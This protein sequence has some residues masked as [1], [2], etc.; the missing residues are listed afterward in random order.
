MAERSFWENHAGGRP[1]RHG[2]TAWERLMWIRCHCGSTDCTGE[3]VLRASSDG[4][5]EG[6]CPE[7]GV[8]WRLVG[9]R[10]RGEGSPVDGSLVTA[11][12]CECGHP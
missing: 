3:V 9:G 7:C 10:L 11:D 1:K 12:T 5:A 2:R 4:G 8:A 6:T